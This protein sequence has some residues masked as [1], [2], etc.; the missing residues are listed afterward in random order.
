MKEAA[1]TVHISN[2]WV[3]FSL[4]VLVHQLMSYLVL[5]QDYLFFLSDKLKAQL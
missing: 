2:G 1:D 3:S 5:L 4:G